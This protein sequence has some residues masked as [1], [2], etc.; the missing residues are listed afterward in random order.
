[1]P[2]WPRPGRHVTAHGP[3]V[4]VGKSHLAAALGHQTCR[5]G[6]DVA[7]TTSSKRSA[8]RRARRPQ[9]RDPRPMSAA[10]RDGAV[11][12]EPWRAGK[13]TRVGGLISEYRLVA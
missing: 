6:Y 2:G 1:M 8:G 3:T 13:C 7:F 12:L 10:Q 4:W 5:R 9:L 11:D